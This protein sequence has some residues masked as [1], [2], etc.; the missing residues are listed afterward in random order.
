MSTKSKAVTSAT[1]T[2]VTATE[3]S[4]SFEAK[5]SE[6]HRAQEE[7]YSKLTQVYQCYSQLILS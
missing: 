3:Q 4:P 6:L 2:S 7:Q 1:E 5:L